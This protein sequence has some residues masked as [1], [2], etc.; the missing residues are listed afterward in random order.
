MKRLRLES[1]NALSIQSALSLVAG[2]AWAGAAAPGPGASTAAFTPGPVTI[3][4]EV[5]VGAVAGII[6][7]AIGA[8]EF[9][10]RIVR[11]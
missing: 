4:W 6:P 9:G 1:H 7:F 2:A 3:G 5:W 11:P 8:Y 10:K